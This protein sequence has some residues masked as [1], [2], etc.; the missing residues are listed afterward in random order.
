MFVPDN[1]K[2]EYATNFFVS[3]YKCLEHSRL[4]V[5]WGAAGGAAGAYEAALHYALKRKQF[6]RPIAG[7]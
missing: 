7:F 4:K 1:N 6:G 3:A 5:C 2:L